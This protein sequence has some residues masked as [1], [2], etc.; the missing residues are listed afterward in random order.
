MHEKKLAGLKRDLD[1]LEEKNPKEYR[2]LEEQIDVVSE[3]ADLKVHQTLKRKMKN[4]S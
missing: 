3:T 2:K 1:F 4:V